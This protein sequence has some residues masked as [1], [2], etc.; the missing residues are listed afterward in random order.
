MKTFH[1]FSCCE[2][3]IT[4]MTSYFRIRDEVIKIFLNFT[5]FLPIV[6]SYQVSESSDLNQKKFWKI[7][8]FDHVFSQALSL[9]IGYHGNNEWPIPKKMACII[10]LKL[11]K[12]GEDHFNSFWDI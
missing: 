12:F 1:F 11:I 6:C 10:F 5:R 8:L 7:F 4:I 3:K 2:I 9:L